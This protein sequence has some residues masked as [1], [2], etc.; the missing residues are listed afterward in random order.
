MNTLQ[1]QRYLDKIG[2]LNNIDL[3]LRE[4]DI[5][6]CVLSGH[7]EKT[8]S[9]LLNIKEST[10]GRYYAN[11]KKK[12]AIETKENLISLI[13][14]AT[15]IVMYKKHAWLLQVE[16]TIFEYAKEHNLRQTIFLVSVS[17]NSSP[18]FLDLLKRHMKIFNIILQIKND[19]PE[20]VNAV[21]D[22]VFTPIKDNDRVQHALCVHFQN[23]CMNSSDRDIY[24]RQS[25][26]YFDF[27]ITI[28]EKLNPDINTFYIK[29]KIRNL[30]SKQEEGFQKMHEPVA[31]VDTETLDKNRR[32]MP[33][34][35]KIWLLSSAIILISSL[36]L[37]IPSISTQKIIRHNLQSIGILGP[38]N[39]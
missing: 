5:I 34:A 38:Q 26:E 25:I 21:L 16:K 3:T 18:L 7:I 20:N 30:L 33:T 36:M 13:E 24:F 2:T 14:T 8:M 28:L 12:L 22:L 11:L 19:I 23:D 35:K 31:E 15:S 6:A 27:F 32:E 39:S 29:Q 10:Y 1:P 4:V 37:L 9:S 17:K